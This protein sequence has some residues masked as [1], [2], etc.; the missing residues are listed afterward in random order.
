[1]SSTVRSCCVFVG[2]GGGFSRLGTATGE[3]PKLRGPYLEGHGDLV[4]RVIM[5]ISRVTIWAMGNIN[6]LTKVP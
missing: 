2:R 5:G 6:L 1:M 4:S 3:F